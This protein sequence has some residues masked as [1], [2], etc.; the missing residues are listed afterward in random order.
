[1]R[2]LQSWPVRGILGVRFGIPAA[3]ALIAASWALA[4]PIQA[5]EAPI[6]PEGTFVRITLD[7]GVSPFQSVQYDLTLRGRTVVVTLVKESLCYRGQQERLRLVDGDEARALMDTLKTVKAFGTQAPTSAVQGRARDSKPPGDVP[8]YEFWSAWGGR[9]TRFSV[10]EAILNESPDLM[11]VFVAVRG[12]VTSRVGGL[13]M[14]DLY[15]PSKRLGALTITATEAATATLDGWDT[16]PLPVESLEVVEGD[17]RVLVIGES[18]QTREFRVRVV[19]GGAS[20]IHV[21][22]DGQE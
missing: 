17:H 11:R 16:F 5:Q 9:M 18:G 12:A 1:M 7:G 14:R 2:V 22:L 15:H 19:A 21:L 3:I 13:R 20:R 10:S 4:A 8:R 6:A